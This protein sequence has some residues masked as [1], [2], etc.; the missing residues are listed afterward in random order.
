MF[1]AIVAKREKAK[2]TL[3][4]N[5]ETQPAQNQSAEPTPVALQEL[6]PLAFSRSDLFPGYPWDW[7]LQQR[8]HN[9]F[10]SH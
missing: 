6:N 1:V 10:L 9:K 4:R 5:V 3:T 7:D 2:K 8:E